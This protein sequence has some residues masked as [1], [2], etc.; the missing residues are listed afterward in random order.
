[1]CGSDMLNV[2]DIF[3]CWPDSLN[4]NEF[5]I[6]VNAL[7]PSINFTLESEKNN[8]LPFLDV[9]VHRCD[10][11]FKFE[12]YRKPTNINS[13]IH[14]FSNHEN[15]IKKSVFITMFLRTLNI[16]SPEFFDKEINNIYEIG[17]KHKYD[18]IFLDKCFSSAKKTFYNTKKD[19]KKDLC[20]TLVLPFYEKFVNM[21]NLCRKLN[22]NVVFSYKNK[23]SNILI[24]NTPNFNNKGVVYKINCNSCQ[25]YY[26]GNTGR[27]LEQRVK[28]HKQAI[29]SK[30]TNNALF[31]HY[32]DTGHNFNFNEV[33]IVSKCSHY[34]KRNL[35]ESYFINNSWEE[36]INI[37]P[38]SVKI[39]GISKAI[40]QKHFS[41]S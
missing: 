38:G 30:N 3:I 19:T 34:K 14:N 13:F 18:K 8:T 35:I 25:K 22:L 32:L 6:K 10:R 4:I 28:E 20:N 7:V 41:H 11:D 33:D 24:R 16:V 9:L 31:L 37:H 21:P 5:L 40:L 23:N 2:D 26:I 1:M 15:K 39:D 27:D 17:Y 29:V 12:I 36:N